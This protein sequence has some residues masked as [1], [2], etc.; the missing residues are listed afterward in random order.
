MSEVRECEI[1]MR[2]VLDCGMPLNDY[3]MKVIMK[4][5]GIEFDGVIA[6]RHKG[7]LSTT[8]CHERNVMIVRQEF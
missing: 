8:M 6:L 7:V 4:Q 3:A 2:D 5:K 1:S